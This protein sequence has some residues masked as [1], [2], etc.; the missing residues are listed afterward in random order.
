MSKNNQTF[1]EKTF[2]IVHEG[3]FHVRPATKFAQCAGEFKSQIEIR[4]DS[5]TFGEWVNGKSIMSLLTLA[6]T[7]GT[8][9]RVRVSGDDA[10]DAIQVLA[11]VILHPF[12]D[13][14]E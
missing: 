4:K 2:E 9:I 14:I 1:I 12:S 10:R 5:D 7:Q 6:A 13:D 8:K 3:G 11:E